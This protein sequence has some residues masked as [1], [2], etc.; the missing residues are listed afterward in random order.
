M[1][2]QKTNL[3]HVNH[4]KPFTDTLIIA[5][6]CNFEHAS[7]IKLV[8]KYKDDFEEFGTLRFQ[9]QKSGG[10]KTEY[11]ELTKTKRLI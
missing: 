9:N 11:A 3:V 6:N 8:R 7:V 1:N 10:R 4:G 2:A 5:D